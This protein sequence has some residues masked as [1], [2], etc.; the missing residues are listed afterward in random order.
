MGQWLG[1]IVELISNIYDSV[2]LTGS[3]RCC[4]AVQQIALCYRYG[5]WWCSVSVSKECGKEVMRSAVSHE[6]ETKSLSDNYSFLNVPGH[7]ECPPYNQQ[8]IRSA[9]HVRNIE[10]FKLKQVGE[11][12]VV[13]FCCLFSKNNNK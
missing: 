6:R 2:L 5:M 10:V 7:F 13:F 3:G 11:K 4:M 8:T 12:S 1:L 9:Y